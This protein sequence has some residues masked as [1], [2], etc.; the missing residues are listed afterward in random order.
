MKVGFKIGRAEVSSEENRIAFAV[1]D[2]APGTLKPTQME[3]LR[4]LESRLVSAL[5]DVR[6]LI[7][8]VE[9]VR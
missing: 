1:V 2:I 6:S 3:A 4:E 8:M 5:S 9:A 7:D